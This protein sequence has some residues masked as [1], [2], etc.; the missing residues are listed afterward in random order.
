VNHGPPEGPASAP[1]HGC[2]LVT[3]DLSGAC[4]PFAKCRSPSYLPRADFHSQCNGFGGEPQA[5]SNAALFMKKAV[6]DQKWTREINGK[7][8][9]EI[10]YN[11]Y[12]KVKGTRCADTQ[13]CRATAKEFMSHLQK[14][15]IESFVYRG[16]GSSLEST[17]FLQAG[18]HR[19]DPS[20]STK[21]PLKGMFSRR[22]ELRQSL[23]VYLGFPLWGR[24][25]GG[26]GSKAIGSHS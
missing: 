21:F 20:R 16:R 12:H 14:I 19:F 13:F 4:T 8:L 26:T 18:G 17:C 22:P 1:G 7:A 23:G 11:I 3:A 6:L 9:G 10:V 24:A 15:S 25:G 5:L 2:R